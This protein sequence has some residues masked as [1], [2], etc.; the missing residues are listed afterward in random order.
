MRPIRLKS[1]GPAVAEQLCWQLDRTLPGAVRELRFHPE[2][3]WRFDLAW[4][5]LRL[6]VEI[7]GG[8]FAGGRHARGV[9]FRA[10]IEKYAEAMCLGWRV[11][12]ILPEQVRDGTAAAWLRRIAALAAAQCEAGG[13]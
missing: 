2:R 9:G 5:A 11:L 4:P 13:R 3:R 10:D 12:R 8:V 1:T 6:A 7:E